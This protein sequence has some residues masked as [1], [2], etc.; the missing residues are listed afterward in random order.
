MRRSRFERV[1]MFRRGGILQRAWHIAL[2]ALAPTAIAHAGSDVQIT[3]QIVTYPV[4]GKTPDAIRRSINEQRTKLPQM[5]GAFDAYT[6]T[7]ISWRY[8][9]SR[10]AGVCAVDSVEV[11]LGVR[12]Y[13]PAWEDQAAKPSVAEQWA[14]YQGALMRHEQR[15]VE[16]AKDAADKLA[17]ALRAAPPKPCA[18]LQPSLTV[19]ANRILETAHRATAKM[20]QSSQ[21]GMS[22]GARF[23]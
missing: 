16:I 17:A 22:E 9:A 2:L 5:D 8:T 4:T 11:D 19:V 7:D 1:P 13:L 18:S 10:N 20:D 12:I 14:R 23:P 21:H 6:K 3:Q 15:H